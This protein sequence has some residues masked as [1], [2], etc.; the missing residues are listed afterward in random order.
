MLPGAGPELV[1]LEAH[2]QDELDYSVGFAVGDDRGRGGGALGLTA[3]GSEVGG[4]DAR[5]A[6]AGRAEFAVIGVIESVESFR[7]E[8]DFH[9]LGGGECLGKSAVNVPEA[10]ALEH[11]AAHAGAS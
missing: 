4:E 11:V 5:G 8:H 3:G 6:D 10:G 7:A 9:A 2:F 1:S